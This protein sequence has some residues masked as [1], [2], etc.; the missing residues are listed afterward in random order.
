MNLGGGGGGNLAASERPDAGGDIRRCHIFVV[1]S[2]AGKKKVDWVYRS[3]PA[4]PQQRM[5][6]AY[7]GNKEALSSS[8][9][10]L[11]PVVPQIV[12]M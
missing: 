9:L 12:F 1:A 10:A 11:Q 2:R 3:G 8:Y 6:T 5:G 7:L 4:G